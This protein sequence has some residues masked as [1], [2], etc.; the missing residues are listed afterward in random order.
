M[1][2]AKMF[3]SATMIVLQENIAGVHTTTF[4]VQLRNVR[5]RT[6]S[7]QMFGS[8]AGSPRFTREHF[9]VRRAL[10]TIRVRFLER[11]AIRSTPTGVVVNIRKSEVQ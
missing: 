5:T 6:Q 2:V 4:A 3:V 7:S 9:A 1:K 8:G 11:R 10:G